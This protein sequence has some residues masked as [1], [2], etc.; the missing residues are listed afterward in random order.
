MADPQVLKKE[1][2]SLYDFLSAC[3]NRDGGI[4]YS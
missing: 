2:A 3:I 1:R 4:K